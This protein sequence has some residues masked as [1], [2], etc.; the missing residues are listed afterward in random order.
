[1]FQHDGRQSGNGCSDYANLKKHLRGKT[2]EE[3]WDELDALHEKEVQTGIDADPHIVQEYI[4]AIEEASQEPEDPDDFDQAWERFTASHPDLF[5]VDEPTP[6]EAPVIAEVPTAIEKPVAS[7]APAHAKPAKATKKARRCPPIGRL[8]L[9]ATLAGVLITGTAV[10]YQWPDYIIT[11]GKE[12][13]GIAPATSGSMVLSEPTEEGFTTIEDAL[14]YIGASDATTPT[15]IPER[16]AIQRVSVQE[17]SEYSMAVAVFASSDSNLIIRVSNYIDLE[18]LPDFDIEK[19]NGENRREYKYEAESYF[20]VENTDTLQVTWK[21]GTCLYSFAGDI[22]EQEMK[23]MIKSIY[24][25][26]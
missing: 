18:D 19:D 4:T 12:I 10:A 2:I 14:E 23:S 6:V 1:M 21:K 17:T 15:W 20:W 24:G 9:A 3:L 25:V 8:L 11:W 13:L 7:K 22:S 5:P 16:Y 26:E